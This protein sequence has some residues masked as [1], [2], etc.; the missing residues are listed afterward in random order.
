MKRNIVFHRFNWTYAE[1]PD[2]PV[3]LYN[4]AAVY[5]MTIGCFGMAANLSI[6]IVFCAKSKVN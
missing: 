4:V 6:L 2:L 3:W 5:L 1:Q